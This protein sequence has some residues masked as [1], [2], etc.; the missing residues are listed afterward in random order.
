MQIPA[1]LCRQTDLL[2]AAAKQIKLLMLKKG[3][4]VAPWD[5]GNIIKKIEHFNNKNI[6]LT[7]RGTCFGYN[8]LVSD[9]RSLPIMAQTGYPVIFD[10]THSVQQPG[11]LE[12][13]VVAKENLLKFLPGAQLVLVLLRYLWK[14]IKILITHRQMVLAWSG[15]KI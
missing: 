3:Q 10:A 8:N 5:V 13:Q 4:F 11:V 7:E 15:Y 14:F 2:A 1:F 12:M 9:M 6:L